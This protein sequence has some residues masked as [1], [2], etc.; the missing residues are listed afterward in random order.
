M[1]EIVKPILFRMGPEAAHSLVTGGVRATQSFV[2]PI[3]HP[4]YSYDRPELKQFLW[5]VFFA[6]P[7]GLAAG[8]DKNATM[9]RALSSL[10]F[11]FL[12]VGSV[13]AK[14]SKGNPRPRLFRLESDKALINRMGLNNHGAERIARRI[15][16]IKHKGYAPLG[17]NI[18][19]THDGDIVGEAAIDD[20]RESFRILSPLADYVTLNISCPNTK[21]GTTFEEPAALTELL[22]AIFELRREMN[23]EVPVLVKLA[24]PL[25]DKVVFDSL[26][27]EIVSVC[28]EKGVHGFVA[29]NTAPDRKNLKTSSAR[30]Q[31]IGSGGLSGRPLFKRST[32]LVNYIYSRVDRKVPIIGVG[33]IDSAE[34]AFEKI[35]AGA[36]LVQV[37]TGLV[38]KGPRLVKSIKSGMY[39]LLKKHGF[40]SIKDAVGSG[41]EALHEAVDQ[42]IIK[43]TG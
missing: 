23:S 8:F 25:S 35:L 21:E 42:S 32:M 10:G 1:Y 16:R 6:S 39:Q 38:Y 3:I 9:A 14:P 22:D 18:A 41:T 40:A 5:R 24:P 37:Y 19:K 15:K 29:S 11:G 34:A 33:G 31:K 36:S 4:V 2:P 20:F 17:I 7:V 12:E 28:I 30:L 43:P 26:I 27:E 13:T